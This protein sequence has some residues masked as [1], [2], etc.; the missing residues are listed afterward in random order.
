MFHS[1]YGH[2]MFT[3]S[4]VVFFVKS[5]KN[6]LFYLSL[7]ESPFNSDKSLAELEILLYLYYI[8]LNILPYLLNTHQFYIPFII[9]YIYEVLQLK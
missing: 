3:M 6:F 7:M 2:K 8:L 4:K 9:N 1:I 5:G